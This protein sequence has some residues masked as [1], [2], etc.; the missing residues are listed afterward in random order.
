MAKLIEA[1]MELRK[2]QSLL[3]EAY[4]GDAAA[5]TPGLSCAINTLERVIDK[6][7]MEAWLQEARRAMAAAPGPTAAA[8]AHGE[9][10]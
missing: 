3:G 6:V 2:A 4:A 9:L 8:V 7:K 5:R 10:F 1:A